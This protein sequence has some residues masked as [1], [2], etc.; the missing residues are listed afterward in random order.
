MSERFGTSATIKSVRSKITTRV[1]LDH[2]SMQACTQNHEF[3]ALYSTVIYLL[4][5][6]RYA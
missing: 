6:E 2:E 1:G 3:D 5:L 4:S